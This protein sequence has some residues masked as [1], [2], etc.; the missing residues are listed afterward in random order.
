MDTKILALY[1]PQF[2]ETE[3]NNNWWGKGY[4]EW[5]ACKNAKPLYKN[6]YQPRAPLNNDYYELTDVDT[7]RWQSNIAKDHG[8]DGFAIYH[9]Y[10][11]GQKLL[12]KPTELLLKNKDI[13]TE[14]CL[15]WANHDWRRNWFGREPELL[16]KQE[17]GDKQDW[18]AHFDYCKDYFIDKRYIKLENKPVFF[19]FEANNFKKLDEFIQCWNEKAKKLGF[20][21][22]YFVKTIGPRSTL[23]KG[24][25]DAVFEREPMY[26]LRYGISKQKYL[27]SRFLMLK[28]RIL[29]KLLKKFNIGILESSFS[30]KNCWENIIN[31]TPKQ[32]NTILG[33]FTDWDNTPRRSYDGM[34]MKG[35]T[36]ELFQYYMEKQMERCKEYKSPFVV[37]NAWN[38]WAE[39]A[40]LEPDEKYGY[41]FLNAI[42]NCKN[43]KSGE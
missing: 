10:S 4:T 34:I 5:V 19:I 38:E 28:N 40:Y 30:Y 2:Y 21:G 39:G 43:V 37:I 33:G 24:K 1:L 36:P 11:K 13:A 32:D 14:F 27:F 8:I 16:F 35:T 7:L 3:Y 9:Y 23:D 42:K 15:Y 6:H 25:C 18:I 20:D 29:N 17:Y 31:R 22:I 26:T 12:E 41:A